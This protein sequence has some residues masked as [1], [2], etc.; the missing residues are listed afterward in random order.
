MCAVAVGRAVVGHRRRFV[1]M[2]GGVWCHDGLMGIWGYGT[3]GRG[4][5]VHRL[6]SG[7]GGAEPV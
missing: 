6:G 3:N 1:D 7:A 4:G 5:V 2:G